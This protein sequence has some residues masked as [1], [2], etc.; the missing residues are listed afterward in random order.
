MNNDALRALREDL[1][2]EEALVRVKRRIVHILSKLPD[3]DA[4]RRVISAVTILLGYKE[5]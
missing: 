5:P 3:D 2:R 1:K 4:R